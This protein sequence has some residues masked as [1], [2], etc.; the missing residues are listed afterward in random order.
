M[1]AAMENAPGKQKAER[2][3][4]VELVL[5][6][7]V[8]L[9]V[10]F[11]LFWLADELALGPDW[12]FGV[13]MGLVFLWVVG[14]GYRSKLRDPAFIAFFTAW[15]VIHIAVFLL[16]LRRLGFLYYIPLVPLELWVGY[17]VAILR[18]GPPSPSK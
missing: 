6:V 5:L 18:F 12:A 17:Y 4:L 3:R 16:V 11:L 1:R 9:P 8:G 13:G 2:N 15:L 7:V 14:R 10:S